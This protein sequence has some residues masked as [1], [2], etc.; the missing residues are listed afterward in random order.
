[1]S[2]FSL[3]IAVALSQVALRS[4]VCECGEEEEEGEGEGGKWGRVEVWK[5]PSS[6]LRLLAK[7]IQL[8]PR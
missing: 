7:E 1:M 4:C 2:I 3:S 8:H 6:S 5:V